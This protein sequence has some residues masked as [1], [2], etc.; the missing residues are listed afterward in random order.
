MN[1]TLT[2]NGRLKQK[3][4]VYRKNYNA[5][6][7]ITLLIGMGALA[8]SLIG[9]FSPGNA[10]DQKKLETSTDF[11]ARTVPKKIKKIPTTNHRKY[12]DPSLETMYATNT[13]NV[14]LLPS[15]ILNDSMVP[16]RD[17]NTT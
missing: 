9:G 14:E 4:D 12:Y 5:W 15:E 16:Y 13:Q 3:N 17:T 8:F 6:I 7:I 1:K 10:S 11:P 2:W